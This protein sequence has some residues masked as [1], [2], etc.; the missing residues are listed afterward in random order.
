MRNLLPLWTPPADAPVDAAARA[1]LKRAHVALPEIP[2]DTGATVT[3]L[4]C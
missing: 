4:L 2:E 3:D 1:A